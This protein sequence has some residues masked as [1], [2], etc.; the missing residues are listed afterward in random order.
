MNHQR[1]STCALSP[2]GRRIHVIGNSASGKT[3]LAKRLALV[4]DVDFVEL[5]ALNW[6]PNWVGLNATNPDEL[7]RRFETATNGDGWIAAGSYT[8][9]AKQTFW[10]RLDTVIWLD[11][12]IPVLLW[13]V[14]RRSWRRWRSK[15]LLWGT[16][17]ERFWP[18]LAFWRGDDSLIYWI[19]S[20][21]R[22]KRESMLA[23]MADPCWRKIRFVRLT[24][25]QEIE[26]FATS[27][28]RALSEIT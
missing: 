15:Q 10:S 26:S 14:V 7:R 18:Q 12:P 24:S 11:L 23:S 19:I 13:R 4:L 25:T 6:L 2:I 3:S 16:N 8:Q 9:F 27:I 28:E 1:E 22:R 20:A 21:Q 5:D 17:F